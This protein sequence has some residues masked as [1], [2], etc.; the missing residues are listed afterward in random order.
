M[1]F[2][3][4]LPRLCFPAEL[5]QINTN[6]SILWGKRV[7]SWKIP[8]WFGSLRVWKL[9]FRD[10]WMHFCTEQRLWILFLFSSIVVTEFGGISSWLL[11]TEG[12]IIS[13]WKLL[14]YSWN[15]QIPRTSVSQVDDRVEADISCTFPGLYFKS[16]GLLALICM[17]YRSKLIRY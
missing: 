3:L 12:T 17:I 5:K 15:N 7:W 8:I 16:G 13:N 9:R 10:T 6:T 14:P 4:C 2:S 1:R 11:Q